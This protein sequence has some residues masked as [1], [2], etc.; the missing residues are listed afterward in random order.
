MK[1]FAFFPGCVLE[2]AAKEAKTAILAVAEKLDIVL[3]E[4]PAWSCC[5]ATHVQDIDPFTGLVTNARNLA[6]AE[7]MNLPLIT[8]CSTC[9][10]VLANARAA[11]ADEAT[12]AQVN[13]VLSTE[14]YTYNGTATVQHL[15]WE[16]LEQ[17]SLLQ[18]RV[19]CSLN[20]MKVA[21]FYGC[22]T[23]RA[24]K[25]QDAE[26]YNPKGF[27]QLL[28]IV[29]AEPISYDSRLRCCG[30]HAVFPAEQQVMKLNASIVDSAIDAGAQCLVTPC[31]LCQMQLDMNQPAYL[32]GHSGK[33]LPILYFTQ[34]LGMALGC[35]TKSLGLHRNIVPAS[36]LLQSIAS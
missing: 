36:S 21:T 32:K 18:E 5:G 35:D 24:K 15:L 17:K 7:Q 1:R 13:A 4:I 23:I 34:L 25:K 14:G 2:A 29:G 22:H 12:R 8:G 31:P 10:M 33:K 6:I 26:S 11:L 27:E 3:E 19:R 28:T 16:I 20:G 9:S 30:F